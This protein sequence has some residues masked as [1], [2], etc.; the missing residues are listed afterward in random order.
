[1][2]EFTGWLLDVYA[3]EQR[4]T[5]WLLGEYGERRCLHQAFPVTF[6]VASPTV[7][8]PNGRAPDLRAAW[9]WLSA[10]KEPMHLA[11]AE[12]RD[13]F[14]G[15][16][17]VLSIQVQHP[18]DLPGLFRRF[19]T[20]FPNLTFY[21]ADLPISLRYAAVFGVFALCHCR[22]DVQ[23]NEVNAITAL[24][25]PWDLDPEYPPLR[26]LGLELDCNPAHAEPTGIIFFY[27]Y[28]QPLE[29]VRG[30][31]AKL[32]E[33]GQ[34]STAH[35]PTATTTTAPPNQGCSLWSACCIILNDKSNDSRPGRQ[36]ISK[37]NYQDSAPCRTSK[38]QYIQLAFSLS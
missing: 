27:R 2:A 5:V 38:V 28:R 29:P 24:D 11:R 17:P 15:P 14:A 36:V 12:R 6:Y 34:N 4:L 19:S 23:G 33:S 3:G 18:G 26:V 21:D 35:F 13:L 1:M 31:L 10:Q 7:Q 37:E 20:A 9:N 8:Q 25:S 30:L 16:L 22:V 32:W